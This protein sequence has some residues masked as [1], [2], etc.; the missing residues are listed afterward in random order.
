MRLPGRL[1][2]AIF[3]STK[4]EIMEYKISPPK[5]GA[6]LECG[7]DIEYGR[8]DKKFCSE[9][10]KNKYHNKLQ[11]DSRSIHRK[12]LRGLEKNYIILSKLHRSG[13]NSASISDLLSLGFRPEYSTSY[14]KVNSHDEFSCFEFRYYISKTRMFNL[15][16]VIP[17]I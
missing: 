14:R 15:Q 1:I 17:L 2:C 6:C 12:V 8:T 7:S 10:C 5:H 11:K 16:K 13:M 3:I 4:T 9:K